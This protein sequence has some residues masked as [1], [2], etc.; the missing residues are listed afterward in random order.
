[1]RATLLLIAVALTGCTVSFD[2]PTFVGVT[3]WPDFDAGPTQPRA[4]LDFVST[5]RIASTAVFA[6]YWGT[7]IGVRAE[8][9]GLG[10]FDDD[11]DLDAIV[12]STGVQSERAVLL[13]SD[14]VPAGARSTFVDVSGA[15]WPAAP[16]A[17]PCDTVAR[18]FLYAPPL[19]IVVP[20]APMWTPCAYRQTAPLAF[21][22]LS[23]VELPLA[24]PA[25]V[26]AAADLDGDGAL[27]LLVGGTGSPTHWL[28][29]ARDHWEERSS[30]P[31]D[32]TDL[33]AAA[34][35]DV[36]GDA[37]LDLV[38][39]SNASTGS[40]HLLHG[41]SAA[42]FAPTSDSVALET[43][44]VGA[45][46]L[47]AADLDGDA[48]ADLAL[49]DV[50]S[51]PA[52]VSFFWNASHDGVLAFDTTTM[53]LAT[54]LGA[55][56][57]LQV[58]TG[59]LDDDGWMD[60]LVTTGGATFVVLQNRGDR[61]F[62]ERTFTASDVNDVHTAALGDVDLDGDLDVVLCWGP[63][64]VPIQRECSFVDNQTNGDDF[65]E[66][67]LRGHAGNANAI[68][69]RVVLFP[70][71]HLG[72]FGARPLIERQVVAS[73]SSHGATLVHVG[74]PPS[75]TFDVRVVWPSGATPT[76]ILG[77]ERGARL[78]VQEP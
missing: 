78:R 37:V 2:L 22:A 39:L 58:M 42:A 69:A 41:S 70:A 4:T 40:A 13:R 9:V 48:R 14:L 51:S 52:T 53:P 64:A 61:T 62:S 43:R 21:T 66:L 45:R 50:D 33:A 19:L 71:G 31:I 38:T 60:V 10:D 17:S 57:Q 6:P 3:R 8:G 54:S 1:M 73:S 75:G 24:G 74:L 44:S 65:L 32:L 59:D 11:G 35:V 12:S 7:N 5:G 36:D 72:D 30:S 46:R 25:D 27:D 55:I 47:A 67:A 29:S 34:F 18:D 26:V 28:W 15:A 63:T 68:G 20:P 23:A 77:V 16:L 56:D 49:F 76:D